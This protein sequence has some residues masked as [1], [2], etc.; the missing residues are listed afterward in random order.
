M[1]SCFPSAPCIASQIKAEL[2]KNLK[3]LR[4]AEAVVVLACG[5][6]VQSLKENDRLGLAVLPGCN[7][8]FGAV[9][10]SQGVFHEKCSLCGECLLDIT[11][12][13]C[14]LTLCAKGLLNGPCG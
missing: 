1:G 6:G 13:I 14:P 8:L 11:A 5:L 10:D 3:I 12:G 7:S 9:M 2:A 4:E